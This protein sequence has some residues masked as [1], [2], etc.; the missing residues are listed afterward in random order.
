MVIDCAARGLRSFDLGVGR[1]DYKS[2]FCNEIEPLFDT[3]LALTPRGR[4][5]APAFGAAIAAKRLIKEKPAL[6]AAVQA[7][8]R[9]RARSRMASS[10]SRK[11]RLTALAQ[12]GLRLSPDAG[13][14]RV[15][16]HADIGEAGGQ[17]RSC[18]E[19]V[20]GS[21]SSSATSTAR[22]ARLAIR[23]VAASATAPASMTTWS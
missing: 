18:A 22:G 23:S 2:F 4:L 17:Q 13:P 15:D 10:E 16:Q 21:S 5:A 14:R 9:L 6:W 3:F 20:A 7:L 19:T 12:R 8:R 11:A 1:A